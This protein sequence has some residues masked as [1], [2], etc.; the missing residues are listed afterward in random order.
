MMKWLWGLAL[1]GSQAWAFDLIDI[2]TVF[3]A[4]VQG[5]H[6]NSSNTCHQINGNQLIQLNNSKINGT[7]G[8]P[9]NFCSIQ[10]DQNN[11]PRCDDG[12]GG[13]EVCAVTGSDI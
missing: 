4:V 5:H 1:L 10:P 7:G 3:P 8:L 12:A 2:G 6:G 11:T 9:L 13:Y